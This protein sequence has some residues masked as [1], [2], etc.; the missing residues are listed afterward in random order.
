M[1]NCAGGLRQCRQA[2]ASSSD[3]LAIARGR[4][5]GL[6]DLSEGH[7]FTLL[8]GERTLE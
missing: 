7:P 2:F 5:G 3:V 1:R 8:A 4:R 6:A